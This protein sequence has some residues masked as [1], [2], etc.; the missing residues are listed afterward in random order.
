MG[1]IDYSDQLLIF[2]PA[3]FDVMPVHLIGVGGIGS[4]VAVALGN[5]GIRE[6]HV[7][8]PDVVEAHNLPPQLPY[9]LSDVGSRKVDAL[10]GFFERQELPTTLYT[11]PRRVSDADDLQGVVISGVDSMASRSQIWEIVNFNPSVLFYLDG[12]IGGENY[13]LFSVNPCDP[14]SFGFYESAWLFPDSEGSDLPCSER[15]VIHTPLVLAGLIAA[16]LTQYYRGLPVRPHV[17]GNL[18]QTEQMLLT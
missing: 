9:R 18:K 3:S 11:H 15:T 7:Y 12:R 2:D 6:L 1:S 17:Y 13:Q 8:D 10:A 16:H 4:A 5:L 14:D